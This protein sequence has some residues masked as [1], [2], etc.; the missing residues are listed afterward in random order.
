M[1]FGYYTY[2]KLISLFALMTDDN[3]PYQ[4]PNE[5]VALLEYKRIL[6]IGMSNYIIKVSKNLANLSD[7]VLNTILR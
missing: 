2:D 6:I 4:I 1:E 3:A 5:R 7:R